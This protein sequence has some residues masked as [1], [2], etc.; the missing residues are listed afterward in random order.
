MLSWNEV[1]MLL[2]VAK[3]RNIS[4]AAD[5][6]YMTQ[7]ALSKKLREAE[8]SLG[9]PVFERGRGKKKM[10]LTPKGA[11]L[12]PLLYKMKDLQAQAKDIKRL[13]GKKRLS[14]ASSDGPY[15]LVVDRII[16]RLYQQDPR[17]EF[18]LLLKNYKNCINAVADEQA[19]IAFIGDTPFSRKGVD[20]FP[21][22]REEMVCVAPKGMLE[23]GGPVDPL[24]LD[25]EK[26]I[27]SPYSYELTTWFRS[28][29]HNRPP[30]IHCELIEEV[31]YFIEALHLW[32]I[33]PISVAERL[34]HLIP[35]G[36]DI[37]VLSVEVPARTIYYAV[38]K[39]G[40]S[41][42][43]RKLLD[44]IRQFLDKKDKIKVYA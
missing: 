9:Y 20:T 44:M 3:F 31:R 4:R 29:Y 34:E 10:E 7:P 39:N 16:H 30:L 23:N 41:P 14:I 15:F 22:Y 28:T 43:I 12:L 1:D 11:L 8:E 24:G 17:W 5:E 42:E 27:F 32:S 13:E 19:D 6:S 33:V 40:G 37:H 26:A 25:L 21:L 38:Q 35:D 36:V 18:R 2:T